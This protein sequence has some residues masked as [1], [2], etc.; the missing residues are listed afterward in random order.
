MTRIDFYI[1]ENQDPRSQ[2]KLACRITDKAW[3]QQHKVYIHTNTLAQSQQLDDL[4]WVF[5]DGS[6]LPH[7]L[8]QTDIARDTPVLIGHDHEPEHINDVLINLADDVPPFYS[9]FQRVVEL[10]GGDE[11]MKQKARDRFKYYRD[12]GHAIETHNL[13][14]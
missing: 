3:Q 4:L 2:D 12:R 13:S 10:V 7:S 14:G 11:T 8:Y 9:R 6:F 1:L 5:Q